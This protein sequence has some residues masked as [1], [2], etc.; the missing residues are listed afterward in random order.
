[1]PTHVSNIWKR[2]GEAWKCILE[3]VMVLTLHDNHEFRNSHLCWNL[4]FKGFQGIKWLTLIGME[5]VLL[6]TYGRF[7]TTKPWK[8]LKLLMSS[9]L[10]NGS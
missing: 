9:H 2:I 1:M 8:P 6:G 4:E 5:I 10:I 7:R 3:H